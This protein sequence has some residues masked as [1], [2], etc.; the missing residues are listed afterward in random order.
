MGLNRNIFLLIG[1]LLAFYSEASAQ[2]NLFYTDKYDANYFSNSSKTQTELYFGSDLF[3]SLNS[4]NINQVVNYID[5]F[6]TTEN[7]AF[8]KNIVFENENRI[9]INIGKLDATLC[10]KLSEVWYE[11][12]KIDFLKLVS[13][14][15]DEINKDSISGTSKKLI[16]NTLISDERSRFFNPSN[17]V[18]NISLAF[19]IPKILSDNNFKIVF[20]HF[21]TKRYSAKESQLTATEVINNN[22]LKSDEIKF[23]F[24]SLNRQTFLKNCLSLTILENLIP[25]IYFKTDYYINQC[26]TSFQVTVADTN[27]TEFSV[28]LDTNLLSEKQFAGELKKA[29]NQILS[30]SNEQLFYYSYYDIQK[31]K[32][33]QEEYNLA[34][35]KKQIVRLN[36]R[37]K[38]IVSI[39]EVNSFKMGEMNLST[40]KR[41][42]FNKEIAFKTNS[43][44]FENEVDTTLLVKLEQFLKVNTNYAL[45]INSTSKPSEYLFIEKEKRLALINQYQETGYVI[46]SKKNLALYRSL[47]IFSRFTNS[48]IDYKRLKCTGLTDNSSALY[49]NISSL[50]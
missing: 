46:S 42:D 19:I 2:N 35:F 28:F 29:F 33:M 27:I 14:Q 25:S 32:A 21:N 1:L 22:D 39:N 15:I 7:I 24:P 3:Q 11:K 5:S 45:S 13:L 47:I 12:Y 44:Q 31:L 36:S 20:T 37:K 38:F 50:D 4:E 10:N 43:I 6:L 8:D 40:F 9:K 30:I 16:F 49:L 26:I 18:S 34:E 41:S 48:G 23:D 17:S